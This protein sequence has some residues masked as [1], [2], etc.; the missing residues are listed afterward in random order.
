MQVGSG[1]S[2]CRIPCPCVAEAWNTATVRLRLQLRCGCGCSCSC[3]AVAV[4]DRRHERIPAPS[5]NKTKVTAMFQRIQHEAKRYASEVVPLHGKRVRVRGGVLPM[6]TPHL[7]GMGAVGSIAYASVYMQGA[8]E[9]D[10]RVLTWLVEYCVS[11]DW[12]V[13]GEVLRTDVWRAAD[14]SMQGKTYAQAANIVRGAG[15]Y[16][17]MR[18]ASGGKWI[19]AQV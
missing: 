9:R 2:H 15:G 16:R 7:P 17:L 14:K 11:K 3:G 12:V 10:R 6:G 8:P 5:G 1:E 13:G 4:S 18:L 19:R